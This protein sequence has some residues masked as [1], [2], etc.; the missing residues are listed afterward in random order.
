VYKGVF[1]TLIWLQASRY[2]WQE[3]R[4]WINLRLYGKWLLGHKE[5]YCPPQWFDYYFGFPLQTNGFCREWADFKEGRM[6][7]VEILMFPNGNTP[8]LLRRHQN[9]SPKICGRG[10]TYIQKKQENFFFWPICPIYPFA[11]DFLGKK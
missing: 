10:Y 11:Q 5:E 8:K 3:L 2:L 6:E 1:P 9:T 4:K 7:L